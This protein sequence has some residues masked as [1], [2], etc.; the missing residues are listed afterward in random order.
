MWH[1]LEKRES[2]VMHTGG[3]CS[4][5]FSAVMI[6]MMVCVSQLN[7]VQAKTQGEAIATWKNGMVD[8]ESYDS[9]LRFCD[10]ADS[11]FALQG[12][13]LTIF[14][15]E[16]ARAIGIDKEPVVMLEMAKASQQVFR[17]RLQDDVVSRAVVDLDDIERLR[18]QDPKELHR[19]RKMR[20][21]NIFLKFEDDKDATRAR[22]QAIR[23]DLITG[24]DFGEAARRESQSQ[25]RYSGGRLGWIDPSTLPDAV[26]SAVVD[27]DTGQISQLVETGDGFSI[28]LCEGIRD[29]RAL[30]DEQFDEKAATAMRIM[31]GREG[32][33][34]FVETMQ[35][36]IQ[37]PNSIEPVDGNVRLGG[38][39]MSIEELNA[40][41]S[42]ELGVPDYRSV[43]AEVLSQ[44]LRDWMLGVRMERYAAKKGFGLDPNVKESLH[45]QT[46][47][48][49]AT[50]QFSRL[51]EIR[52]KQPRLE[53]I[54]SFYEE[55][56]QRFQ[57]P[58]AFR[59]AAIHFGDD[60]QET[61]MKRAQVVSK[62]VEDGTL[63]FSDAARQY[64]V[65]PSAKDG[66]TLGWMTAK[67]LFPLGTG[68]G[69]AIRHMENQTPSGL[70]RLESGLW[71]FMKLETRPARMTPFEEAMPEAQAALF[72]RRFQEAEDALRQELIDGLSIQ[73]LA[74]KKNE[75]T[76]I[77]R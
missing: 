16:Q 46:T 41:V 19:P 61:L 27:L 2:S 47:R 43:D 67:D 55:N 73:I 45:W 72:S 66:G 32:W 34:Q 17:Q 59:L 35:Q 53:E 10:V 9:W 15:A 29:G 50:H 65:H 49:L 37:I 63:S 36:E 70:F 77:R 3:P 40:L 26:E 64:S 21:R 69:R 1:G 12:M 68:L 8:R 4:A 5:F 11:A 56:P 75:D 28:F 31:R 33:R 14:L 54:R 52:V 62:K 25:T 71:I 76:A 20:L 60:C 6:G 22:L 42:L 48:I 44:V 13:I 24:A 39:D 51:V 57:S 38:D 58:P 7:S 30:S 74:S 23:A 18:Q